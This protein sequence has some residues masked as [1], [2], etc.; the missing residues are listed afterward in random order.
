M[1][2]QNQ[3]S[4]VEAST[5]LT[6]TQ[7]YMAMIKEVALN[8]NLDVSKMNALI[9]LQE[10]LQNKRAEREYDE[11]MFRLQKS[12]PVIV[13]TSSVAYD[14]V[15][16]KPEQ[17]QKEAFRFAPYDKIESVIRPLYMAEGFSPVSFDTKYGSDGATIYGTLRHSGG[18]KKTVEM[19]L[20]IDSSGGKN[21]LQGMG[22]TLSYGQRYCLKML[23][24]LIFVGEDN[25]GNGVDAAIDN[26]QAVEIDMALNELKMDKPRFFVFMG[27]GKVEDIK[28]KD[29]DKAR[30]AIAVKRSDIKLKQAQS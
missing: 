28:V 4:V 22:S 25:D 27:V 3:V 23:F 17:G 10:R 11:A 29:L 16:G 30:N 26:E 13:K 19:R 8:P 20:P 12:L 18:F 6:Q 15:K 21:N 5:Q 9:D 24:N 2:K 1:D 7:E 14:L